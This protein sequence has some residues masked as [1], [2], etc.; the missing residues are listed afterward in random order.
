MGREDLV[1]LELSSFQ[2]ERT[3]RVRWSP[4]VAVLTNIAANHLDW[5]GSFAAYVAAKLNIVRFQEP[6]RDWIVISDQPELH[7]H[8]EALFGDLAGI[9]R[10]RLDGQTPTAACQTTSASEFD[11][12][13]QRWEGLRLS[14]PG[15]HNLENAAAAATVAHLL[16]VPPVAVSAALTSFPGL[17]HRLQC[18]CVREG[19]EYY[20]DSKSTT[21]EA[22]IM[23]MNAIAGPLLLILGGYDKGSDL[24]SVAQAAAAR[25]RFSACVG[26][27]G[28]RIVELIRAAGGQAEY[29]EGFAQAVA[30]CRD[31]AQPGDA[32][33]LSPACASWD[34]F[35]DYR[36]R[37]EVFARLVRE[38]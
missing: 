9:W 16:D 35:E 32:V 2:L 7:R 13:R 31:R 25:A 10:Y 29:F 26:A 12:R 21:P 27:T 11:D 3:P 5:H 19:V 36:Q 37:G 24:S 34:M 17:P 18:V 20:D 6:G 23:A 30:A 14:I 8:F 33:L 4:H 22:A 28:P 1:V 38:S 15:R